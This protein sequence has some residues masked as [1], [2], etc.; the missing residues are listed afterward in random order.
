MAG[1][2]EFRELPNTPL[3]SLL[4]GRYNRASLRDAIDGLVISDLLMMSEDSFVS[5]L[6]PKDQLIARAWWR[7][8]LT[9]IRTA[10]MEFD[11]L[12]ESRGVIEIAVKKLQRLVSD[13]VYPY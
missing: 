5:A 13:G 7:S 11:N 4:R 12:R 2:P 9:E 6:K 8:A 3:T 1:I 10:Y